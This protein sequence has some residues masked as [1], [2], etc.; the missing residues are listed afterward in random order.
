MH[1]NFRQPMKNE[2]KIQRFWKKIPALGRHGIRFLLIL[3]I[4]FLV[5]VLALNLIKGGIHQS[6]RYLKT[7]IENNLHTTVQIDRIETDFATYMIWHHATFYHPFKPE[8]I[9]ITA[10][11]VIIRFDLLSLL[12]NLDRNPLIYIEEVELEQPILFVDVSL[13]EW[14]FLQGSDEVMDYLDLDILVQNGTIISRLFEEEIGTTLFTG[15]HGIWD[16]AQYGHRVALRT[17]VKSNNPYIPLNTTLSLEVCIE[18]NFNDIDLRGE[19]QDLVLNQAML[20]NM[21]FTAIPFH[22]NLHGERLQF[23]TYPHDQL[24]IKPAG[25]STTKS[26]VPRFSFPAVY[27]GG[28]LDKGSMFVTLPIQKAHPAI[29]YLYEYIWGFLPLDGMAQTTESLGWDWYQSRPHPLGHLTARLENGELEY[30]AYLE[31]EDILSKGD[32]LLIDLHGNTDRFWMRDLIYKGKNPASIHLSGE[33]SFKQGP[34]ISHLHIQDFQYEGWNASSAFLI[35]QLRPRYYHIALIKPKLEGQIDSHRTKIPIPTRELYVTLLDEAITVELDATIKP[36]FDLGVKVTFPF[37]QTRMIDYHL[38]I[39][40][41]DVGYVNQFQFVGYSM[42]GI[43]A[44]GY[45][46]GKINPN[47][48]ERSTVGGVL[49]VTETASVHYDRSQAV[50]LATLYFDF[51]KARGLQL[52]EL[53]AMDGSVRAQG[54][55]TYRN[56]RL[57]SQFD[58]RVEGEPY[59]LETNVLNLGEGRFAGDIAINMADQQLYLKGAAGLID[60][61]RMYADITLAGLQEEITLAGSFGLNL[62]RL[63]PQVRITYGPTMNLRVAGGLSVFLQDKQ[64]LAALDINANGTEARVTGSTS[65]SEDSWQ[66]LFPDLHIQMDQQNIKVAGELDLT[67]LNRGYGDLDITYNETFI[68]LTGYYRIEKQEVYVDLQSLINE[69]EY[70]IEGGIRWSP[71]SIVPEFTI[72]VAG[73]VITI[74]GAIDLKET[75]DGLR[76]T[77]DEFHLDLPSYPVV[78]DGSLEYFNRYLFPDIRFTLPDDSIHTLKGRLVFFDDYVEVAGLIDKQAEIRGSIQAGN[79]DFKFLTNKYQ[80]PYPIKIAQ[81]YYQ[82]PAARA[83]SID[84]DGMVWEYITISNEIDFHLRDSTL[85]VDGNATVED[86]PI[87]HPNWEAEVTFRYET[88]IYA[89]LTNLS[90]QLND[91]SISFAKNVVARFSGRLGVDPSGIWN[92]YLTEKGEHFLV[93]GRY[94]GNTDQITAQLTV[95]DLN[96]LALN[97]YRFIDPQMQLASNEGSFLRYLN[98]VRGM[99]LD[100]R[101]SGALKNPD[102][103]ISQLSV[104]NINLLPQTPMQRSNTNPYAPLANTPRDQNITL[105]I[106]DLYKRKNDLGLAYLEAK[107]NNTK[108]RLE[109]VVYLSSDPVHDTFEEFLAEPVHLDNHFSISKAFFET[110]S[111]RTPLGGELTNLSWKPN[112]NDA[113]AID[114][115]LDIE[116]IGMHLDQ[117]RASWEQTHV[118]IGE[119]WLFNINGVLNLA[120]ED[121]YTTGHI[122]IHGERGQYEGMLMLELSGFKSNQTMLPDFRFT[123]ILENEIWYILPNDHAISGQVGYLDDSLL[124]D[125]FYEKQGDTNQAHLHGEITFSSLL[126]INKAWLDLQLVSNIPSISFL[127]AFFPEKFS[128]DGNL[129]SDLTIQGP[130]FEPTIQGKVQMKNGELHSPDPMFPVHLTQIFFTLNFNKQHRDGQDQHLIHLPVENIQ[131]KGWNGYVTG[132]GK[133]LYSLDEETWNIYGLTLHVESLKEYPCDTT[134]DF[135]FLKFEGLVDIVD[136]HVIIDFMDFKI[137]T[138]G[139]LMPRDGQ[140]DFLLGRFVQSMDQAPPPYREIVYLSNLRLVPGPDLNVKLLQE[141]MVDLGW[142]A[143]LFPGFNLVDAVIARKDPSEESS[144]R[145]KHG[146][147]IPIVSARNDSVKSIQETIPACK[148]VDSLVLFGNVGG[149]PLPLVL[150]GSIQ[151]ARGVINFFHNRLRIEKAILTFRGMNYVETADPSPGNRSFTYNTELGLQVALELKASII[152]KDKFGNPTKITF[153]FNDTVDRLWDENFSLL[154]Q[155]RAP[156]KSQREVQQLLGLGQI[157]STIEE[158]FD[159]DMQQLA[160]DHPELQSI[161]G[162]METMVVANIVEQFFQLILSRTLGDQVAN[163]IGFHLDTNFLENLGEQVLDN[164]E[165]LAP[166]VGTNEEV[167]IWDDTEG[168]ISYT[169]SWANNLTF[170]FGGYIQDDQ[171]VENVKFLPKISVDWSL[172]VKSILGT[173]FE[174]ELGNTFESIILDLE[175]GA[176]LRGKNERPGKDKIEPEG[177]LDFELIFVF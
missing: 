176:G 31:F 62:Q 138:G 173:L 160:E 120:F 2:K 99:H 59:T 156:G 129:V 35:R 65:F 87:V 177:R 32:W 25:I 83:M 104:D 91:L 1:E 139:E 86:L 175:A 112:R 111:S 67:D 33:Y 29:Q 20:P 131:M 44:K 171:A 94:N 133:V 63:D 7:L 150:L 68:R 92:L 15:V 124:L 19:L 155:F 116:H 47:A 9:L 38:N 114:Y 147:M 161:T 119:Q 146:S 107:L 149:L 145:S 3:L 70:A 105:L 143:K 141:S 126:E 22:L 27:G 36:I 167:G 110:D 103:S 163:A 54:H 136:L 60:N 17:D 51:D 72:T 79:I 64:F 117:H 81:E 73:E 135:D 43:W 169:P 77:F 130:L 89:L 48:F 106:R 102:I 152:K 154:S 85:I 23:D 56:N 159:L 28:N 4:L 158:E 24:Q 93:N 52:H 53:Y 78:V 165:T 148:L 162:A 109:N 144:C 115:I 98:Y 10:P 142:F 174:T 96:L 5:V 8:E 55:A 26:P 123:T 61:N 13:A 16:M 153:D 100:M 11:T 122:S 21:V 6:E 97:R 76:A 108:I 132:E 30:A 42:E 46:S 75:R 172:D 34:I 95:N 128:I 134:L 121:S 14:S 168:N 88:S 74:D 40:D 84:E 101:I 113:N 125:L 57:I 39:R 80:I 49:A 66:H 71:N 37:K 164:E 41:L 170:Q 166:S 118:E 58:L 137:I 157:A 127:N 90:F 82:N 18:D 50:H 45:L 12:L 151:S 69:D 140:I